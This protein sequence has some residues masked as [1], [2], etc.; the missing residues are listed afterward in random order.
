MS[1]VERFIYAYLLL[2]VGPFI[3]MTVLLSEIG[4]WSLA[5]LPVSAAFW[6]G[7]HEAHRRAHAAQR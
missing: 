4:W 7:L 1:R 2:I 5:L 3:T 6:A